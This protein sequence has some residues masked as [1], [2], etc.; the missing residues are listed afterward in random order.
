[1]YHMKIRRNSIKPLF[2]YVPM[3]LLLWLWLV[4][5]PLRLVMCTFMG[6]LTGFVE[7]LEEL[8]DVFQIESICTYHKRESMGFRAW[9]DAR[10][11]RK[12]EERRVRINIELEEAQWLRSMEAKAYRRRQKEYYVY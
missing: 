7:G 11:A 4:A 6:F 12:R 1:M 9:W 2:R 5:L 10:Q 8:R 3:P